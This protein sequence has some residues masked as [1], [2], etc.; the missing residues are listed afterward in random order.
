MARRHHQVQA[1]R[2]GLACGQHC[3]FKTGQLEQRVMNA[4]LLCLL[5]CA[6]CCW[7]IQPMKL[8]H[9]PPS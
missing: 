9:V 1:Q 8:L 6:G 7:R 5:I 2:A 3:W 4:R